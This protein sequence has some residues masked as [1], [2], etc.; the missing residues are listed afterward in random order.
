MRPT[1]SAIASPRA[2]VQTDLARPTIVFA[3]ELII[4]GYGLQWPETIPAQVQAMTGV[5]AANIA[6]NAHA[7]DQILLRLRRELPRF[8][9]PV[10]VVIP[11]VPSLFDRNLDQDRPYLDAG[12]RWIAAHPPIS[13]SSSSPGA[14]CATAARRPSTRGS[15]PPRRCCARRSRWPARAAPRR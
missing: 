9:H 13:A 12:L 8:A 4:L 1:A 14:S 3:G 10:A 15:R 2:G 5:Q 11:F 6:V 7:T